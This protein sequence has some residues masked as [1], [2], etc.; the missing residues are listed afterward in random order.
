MSGNS[1]RRR[2]QTAPIVW[3][4][5]ARRVLGHGRHRRRN[6][7]RYLPIWTSS[8]SSSTALSIRR[9]FTNVPLR[10]PRSRIVKTLALAGQLRV[11]A[12]DRD[13]V[14]EDVALGRAADE[15]AVAD[16]LE[17]LAG[18]AAARADDERRPVDA[19]PAPASISSGPKLIGRLTGRVA[20][21]QRPA[22]RAVRR[23]LGTLEAAL[24]AV[25]VAHPPPP[26]ID[27]RSSGSTWSPPRVRFV[28]SARM[29]SICACITRRLSEMS[30]SSFSSRA[31]LGPE[32]VVVQTGEI[33]RLELRLQRQVAGALE[34]RPLEGGRRRRVKAP[35]RDLR[36]QAR[37]SLGAED[38]DAPVEDAAAAGD[39]VLRL[40]DLREQRRK[41]VVRQRLEVRERFHGCLSVGDSCSA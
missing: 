22:A 29:M 32:L 35:C 12:R 1:S 24:G 38:V 20:H 9:L 11:A 30:S 41:L 16:R 13:V 28:R 39:L 19:R 25:D 37:R 6:V 17:A 5:P 10:L 18:P 34:D 3:S 8:S 31:D 36:L 14:Q 33:E 4:S 40:F 15:G 26:R 7:I 2:S 23:R 21:E 27:P